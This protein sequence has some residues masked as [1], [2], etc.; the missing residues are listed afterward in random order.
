MALRA[1]SWRPALGLAPPQPSRGQ[2]LQSLG[3]P[4]SRRN[5]GRSASLAAEAH[6][7]ALRHRRPWQESCKVPRGVGRSE[8]EKRKRRTPPSFRGD[9][10]VPW[11]LS[12]GSPRAARLQPFGPG[13]APETG[14]NF[15]LRAAAPG[16][17]V[18][19][20]SPESGGGGPDRESSG[21]CPEF[22]QQLWRPQRLPLSSQDLLLSPARRQ[23]AGWL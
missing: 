14:R 21:I 12:R 18:C 13:R 15:N 17:I 2:R 23:L 16:L 6:P 8:E 1:S 5:P 4:A 11:L 19:S 9:R 3:C 7:A 22:R 20:N 10:G